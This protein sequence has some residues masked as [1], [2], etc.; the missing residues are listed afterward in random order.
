[1]SLTTLDGQIASIIV[2]VSG[3]D[4]CT[5]L[6]LESRRNPFL[7]LQVSLRNYALKMHMISIY[8]YQ[9]KG[10]VTSIFLSFFFLFLFVLFVCLFVVVVGVFLFVFLVGFFCCCHQRSFVGPGA[11]TESVSGGSVRTV[12]Q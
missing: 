2:R 3:T 1:M 9:W 10:H 4:M 12:N 11:D 7:T 8:L 6:G 5:K